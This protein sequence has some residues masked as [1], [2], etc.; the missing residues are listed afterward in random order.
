MAIE[1]LLERLQRWSN[2]DVREQTPAQQQAMLLCSVQKH[3]SELLSTHQGSALIDPTLGLPNNLELTTI[4]NYQT[5]AATISAQISHFEPR[6]TNPSVQVLGLNQ[7]HVCLQ[8]ALSGQLGDDPR[9]IHFLISIKAGN[10][11]VLVEL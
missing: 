6:L 7:A 11:K 10:A 1:R 2:D 4:G 5:L 3:L 9:R 8:F